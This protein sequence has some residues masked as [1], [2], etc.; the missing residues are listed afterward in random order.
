MLPLARPAPIHYDAGA[1]WG[2][3]SM[4]FETL[5]AISLPI[6]FVAFMGIEL[7]APS[8]RDMPKVPYW[9]L[10]GIGALLVTLAFNALLPLAIVPWLPDL[11]VVHLAR[12]GLWAALP[13]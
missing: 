4:D 10:I 3:G 2:R 5:A 8:G 13:A 11:A 6:I 1:R 12:W 7:A 9:R